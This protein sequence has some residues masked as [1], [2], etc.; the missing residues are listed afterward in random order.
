MGHGL[1][2]C[3]S[4]SFFP[5]SHVPTPDLS[6]S[7]PPTHL[8]RSLLYLSPSPLHSYFPWVFV[9]DHSL[10]ICLLFVCLSVFRCSVLLDC[11]WIIIVG[12][13]INIFPYSNM[14][15]LWQFNDIRLKLL[16]YCRSA[17]MSSL[18]DSNNGIYQIMLLLLQVSHLH[19]FCLLSAV[20]FM[21]TRSAWSMLIYLSHSHAH[22]I[23]FVF[24]L[25]CIA[26]S[27]WQHYVCLLALRGSE[28]RGE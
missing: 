11:Y 4:C 13:F 14:C 9:M 25:I 24:C 19:A 7:Q 5:L 2:S 17:A 6:P 27:A 8:C 23:L 20:K 18:T 12:V 26:L 10:M 21:S 1:A 16:S 15:R 3:S 22:S 28:T